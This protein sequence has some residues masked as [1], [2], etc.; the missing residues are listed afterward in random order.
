MIT[1]NGGAVGAHAR[2]GT[3]ALRQR[4]MLGAQRLR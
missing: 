4:A 3:T 2:S 1:P